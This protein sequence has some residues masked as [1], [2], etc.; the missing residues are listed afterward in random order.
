MVEAGVLVILFV[1]SIAYALILVLE[2]RVEGDYD[3]VLEAHCKK[4]INYSV[5]QHHDYNC[6]EYMTEEMLRSKGDKE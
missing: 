6:K 1:A 4:C 3:E 5:C 2:E